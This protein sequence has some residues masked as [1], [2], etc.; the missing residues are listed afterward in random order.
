MEVPRLGVSGTEKGKFQSSE[1]QSSEFQ[2]GEIWRLGVELEH[3][4]TG[5]VLFDVWRTGIWD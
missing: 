3:P 1:F 2:R 4:E 5:R